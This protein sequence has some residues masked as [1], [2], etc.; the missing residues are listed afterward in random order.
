M[1]GSVRRRWLVPTAALLISLTIGATAWAATD[2][3][4]TDST[5]SSGTSSVT[6]PEPGR[7]DFLFGGGHPGGMRGG[8]GDFGG[9]E[10]TD[11]QK[12][13]LEAR[14]Q[15]REARHEAMLDEI[16]A[17]MSADDQAT[18]DQL[19]ATAEQQRDTLEQAR[20]ALRD[21]T[22]Q[23]RDLMGPYID[24]LAPADAPSAGVGSSDSTST[25]GSSDAGSATDGQ[26][27]PTAGGGSI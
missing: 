21:T 5:G 14:R 10:L 22:D 25:T 8:P 15:E 7:G 9:I 4:S 23:M 17:K 1:N 13:E 19:R 3:G 2:S 12:Q 11:E 27:L 26:V 24:E 16:R 20:E 6:A 18:F